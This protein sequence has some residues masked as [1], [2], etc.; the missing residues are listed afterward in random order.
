[1]YIKS[2]IQSPSLLLSFCF[3]NTDVYWSVVHATSFQFCDQLA[4]SYFLVLKIFAVASFSILLIFQ[5]QKTYT[6]LILFWLLYS[7]CKSPHQQSCNSLYIVRVPSFHSS[8]KQLFV[9]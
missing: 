7:V 5:T 9:T 2:S 1:M 6:L 8:L 4:S 3:S